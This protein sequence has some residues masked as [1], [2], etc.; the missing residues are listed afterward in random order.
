[1]QHK[2][3]SKGITVITVMELLRGARTKTEMNQIGRFLATYP[4]L[5]LLQGDSEWAVQQFR[6]YWLSHQ[7]SINDCLIAAI[8]FRTKNRF[9]PLMSKILCLFQDYK[10][11]SPIDLSL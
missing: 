3:L 4:T 9:I 11:L 2:H 6:A 5:H 7:I 10:S 1:M 8:A